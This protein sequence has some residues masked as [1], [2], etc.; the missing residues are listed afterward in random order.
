MDGNP[1][2]KVIDKLAQLQSR[3]VGGI[4][5]PRPEKDQADLIFG[6]AIAS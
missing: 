5:L 4:V 1:A 6:M 3:L 2:K